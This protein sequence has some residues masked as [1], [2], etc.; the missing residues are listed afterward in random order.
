[1]AL[2]TRRA[3]KTEK[4]LEGVEWSLKRVEKAGSILKKELKPI[5]DARAGA[6][7]RML[8]AQNLLLK[9]WSDTKN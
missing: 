2:F 8:A 1:M 4:F 5:S 7:G 3:Y 6:E 9:F